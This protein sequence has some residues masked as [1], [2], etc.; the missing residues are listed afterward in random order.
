MASQKRISIRSDSE[1]E[2]NPL[3]EGPWRSIGGLNSLVF[4]KQI[5]AASVLVRL[6]V[7]PSAEEGPPN[8]LGSPTMKE[9]VPSGTLLRVS[10]AQ[11]IFARSNNSISFLASGGRFGSSTAAFG[12]KA[13]TSPWPLIESALLT[14]TSYCADEKTSAIA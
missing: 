13:K 11:S 1:A 5:Y 12:L 10:I 4:S 9:N 14:V 3:A 7:W 8:Q 2:R 6:W